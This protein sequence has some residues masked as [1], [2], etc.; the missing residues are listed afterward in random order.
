[1]FQKV[2]YSKAMIWEEA[3][4]NSKELNYSGKSE[5]QNTKQKY[6]SAQAEMACS[7]CFEYVSHI[8]TQLIDVYV[9]MIM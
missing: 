6:R 8:V 4:K 3:S 5:K 1:M 2:S 7:V 9:E